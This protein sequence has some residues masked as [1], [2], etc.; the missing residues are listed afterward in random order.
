M[1]FKLIFDPDTLEATSDSNNIFINSISDIDGIFH[2][3]LAIE[4]S[5]PP[6]PAIQVI[7]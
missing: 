7:E 3:E 1:I 4:D 6:N 2:I 5:T